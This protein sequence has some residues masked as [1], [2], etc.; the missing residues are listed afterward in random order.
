MA[1]RRLRKID[2]LEQQLAASGGSLQ[3]TKQIAASLKLLEDRYMA[4]PAAELL[5]EQGA[6]AS[7]QL[8]AGLEATPVLG[9]DP[10][11]DRLR[12]AFK[13]AFAREGIPSEIQEMARAFYA[14]RR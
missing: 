6:P 13:Q 10:H 8:R 7:D 14:R 11:G 12:A 5:V 4:R 1:S 2:L 3:E 9:R